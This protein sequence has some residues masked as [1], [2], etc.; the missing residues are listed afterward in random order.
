MN[1]LGL[2]ETLLIAEAVTGTDALVLARTSRVELLDSALQAPL[3]G[4][5]D[6]DIFPTLLEKAAV[7]CVRIVNNHPLL[8]GNKRLA[9][10]VMVV[11][12]E[13]NGVELQVED[14]DAVETMLSV[15]SG[16]LDELKLTGWLETRVRAL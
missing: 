13:L 7:L 4:F 16:K 15:A 8:D 12:L 10:M 11:F 9:W 1:Y 2:A 5:G 14:D 6:V 3:A